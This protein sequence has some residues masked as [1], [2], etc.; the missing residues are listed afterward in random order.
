M[1]ASNP[2][3]A[4]CLLEAVLSG[5]L[6]LEAPLPSETERPGSAQAALRQFCQAARSAFDERLNQLL[7]ARGL[8]GEVP[9]AHFSG[10]LTD[11][12]VADLTQILQLSGKSAVITIRQDGTQSQL[13]CC[14]GQ[15]VDAES[16]GLRG[17]A[18]VYSILGLEHGTLVADLHAEPRV[19][20]VYASTQSLVLEAARRKDESAL[21][22]QKLGDLQR[23]YR[24]ASQSLEERTL[25][26]TTQRNPTELALLRSF[27][28][29]RSLAEAV[30]TSGLAELEALAALARWVEAGYLIETGARLSSHRSP[31]PSAPPDPTAFEATSRMR[32][33]ARP[34]TISVAPPEPETWRRGAAQW[35]W[36]AL[37]AVAMT[38]P[39]AYVLGTRAA[40]VQRA[41]TETAPAPAAPARE[42][43]ASSYLVEVQ[44]E[45]AEAELQLDGGAPV[46]GHLR[47]SLERNGATHELRA[48]A[49]GFVPARIAFADVAPIAQLR[50]E[51]LASA[52]VCP[53]AAADHQDRPSPAPAAS[54]PR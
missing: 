10:S 50:L 21:Y 3:Q 13:W 31:E 52:G 27:A 15:I 42:A 38:I 12:A 41:P 8:G 35:I 51:P 6:L 4:S 39:A 33:S 2:A 17:E 20:T 37:A 30:A 14:A 32:E 1:I 43:V 22:Q 9:G 36:A 23:V 19:R 53:G 34:F 29:P 16:G 24:L 7:V 46:T 5:Q 26:E 47:V 44:V 18:A 25:D 45:P 49:P 11:L 48:R 54:L 40:Q 28:A